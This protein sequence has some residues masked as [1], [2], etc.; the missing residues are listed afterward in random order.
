[1]HVVPLGVELG[2]FTR[3]ADRAATRAELLGALAAAG[4]PVPPDALLLCSVGRHQ[5]RKGFHW[6][7]DQVMPRLPR[8]VVYLLAGEGPMTPA[9]REAVA[10]HRLHDRVRL[11]GRVPEE[12]LATLLRGADLFVMPNVPVPGD[13]EGFGLVMLE[14]GVCGLPVLAADLEGIRDVVVEG[15]NGHLLPTRDADAF[16]AAVLRYRV[17]PAALASASAAAAAFTEGTFAWPAIV[18]RYVQIYRA[19]RGD[20]ARRAAG[21]LPRAARPGRVT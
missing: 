14:A 2:R 19:R 5:E 17:D 3:V 6:F 13:M 21:V 20:G 9:V 15:R 7:V 10:R 11:L 12:G 18:D 4:T 1:M 16:A 8:D